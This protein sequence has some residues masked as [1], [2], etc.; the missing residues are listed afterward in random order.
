MRHHHRP[1]K[2]LKDTGGD[3][4][5][6]PGD[7]NQIT[8]PGGDPAEAGGE[9]KDEHADQKEALATKDIAQPAERK[10]KDGVGQDVGIEHP[11]DLGQIRVQA[12]TNFD[13]RVVDDRCIEQQ[14]EDRRADDYQ[15]D[16]GIALGCGAG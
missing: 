2:P 13:L 1:A 5:V 6:D 4:G 12:F 8:Q 3:Q 16:P 14:H 10:Q 11:L 7:P 15:D 9:S